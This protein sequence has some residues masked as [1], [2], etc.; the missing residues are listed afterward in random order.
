M[1]RLLER[2]HAF[3]F[4]GAPATRLA[5]LRILVGGYALWY[6]GSRYDLY[7]RMGRSAADLFDPVG[8][9]TLL[10]GPIPPLIFDV[11]VGLTLVANVA[12]VLGWRH[13][14]T[15]PLFGALLLWLLC[16]RNSWSMIYH[17]DNV[18]VLQ[19][20]ILGL[21][22]A[23]AAFSLDAAARRRSERRDGVRHG[24]TAVRDPASDWRFGWPIRLMCM[25]AAIAYVLAGIAKVAGPLGWSWATG[26]A[27][28]GQL[29]ADSLRKELLG[30]GAPDLVF[31]LYGHVWL[32]T[33]I[34]IG[35]LI[36]ELGAVAALWN[37]RV[38]Q[39][40]AVNAFLMHWGIF[41]LMD[42]R[43]LYP[44][45]GVLFAP[46]FRVERVAEWLW[47]ETSS[48]S[49]GQRVLARSSPE[50]ARSAEGLR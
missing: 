9:A 35:T 27:L 33:I 43:F 31:M 50:E 2:L 11:V 30:S 48:Q 19:V 20:L 25:V 44:M 36:I 1:T 6:V 14:Y 3:W 42:I 45:T 10:P 40:W 38:S 41:V 22:P 32:F 26:E 15:G 39:L 7:S 5:A 23:A 47:P 29:A 46:F 13:R 12:F 18:L 16:Y 8:V 28:R 4:A 49:A 34:G 21:T 17:T 24:S 37:R